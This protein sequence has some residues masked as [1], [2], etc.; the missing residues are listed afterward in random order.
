VRALR[1][2]AVAAFLVCLCRLPLQASA[3]TCPAQEY[4]AQVQQAGAALAATPA[5]APAAISLL[6]AAEREYPGAT[7]TLQPIIDDLQLT[8]PALGEARSRLGPLAAVLALPPGSACNIDSGAAASALHSVY[9]SPVFADLDQNPQPSL[10]QQ[11][12]NA[13]GGIVSHL[14]SALGTAGTITLGA[15]VLAAF[16]TVVAWRVRNGLAGRP[17]SVGA[18]PLEAGDDPQAEWAA[19]DRAAQRGDYREAVRRAFRGALL[20]TV[21]RG[22]MRVDAA[23]TT[24]EL[25]AAARGDADLLAALAAAAA[26]FD[27]AWYSGHA[28]SEHD[29]AQARARC[30]AVRTLARR[31]APEPAG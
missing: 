7:E 27:R 26:S 22:R 31:R 9:A 16:L 15:I 19:A 28:V 2:A 12:G 6:T 23:W 3:A 21:I 29:W 17:A 5:D 30:E 18:E 8:P 1:R 10:L 20:D 13:V 11:I 24:R 4:I 25:L 14:F